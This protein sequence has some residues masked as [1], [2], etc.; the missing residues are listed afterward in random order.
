M[1]MYLYSNLKMDIGTVHV[2]S[3]K[4]TNVST[5]IARAWNVINMCNFYLTDS[6]IYC[7]TRYFENTQLIHEQNL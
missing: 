7:N 3:Y 1:I 5:L 4:V 6:K 2:I